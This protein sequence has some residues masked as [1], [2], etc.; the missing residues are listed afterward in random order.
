MLATSP[1]E[2]ESTIVVD[3]NSKRLTILDEIRL[4]TNWDSGGGPAKWTDL[5]FQNGTLRIGESGAPGDL[6]MNDVSYYGNRRGQIMTIDPT[7]TFEPYINILRVG[8]DGSHSESSILD[9]RGVKLP[10][11]F[12][13]TLA[14]NQLIIGDAMTP[15]SIHCASGMFSVSATAAPTRLASV[16]LIKLGS[17]Q[18]A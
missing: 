5:T 7:A 1:D 17:S 18:Q 9:I 11:E 10:L 8:S 2:T 6:V 4:L 15:A 14:V 13:K 12:N 16:T 3:L